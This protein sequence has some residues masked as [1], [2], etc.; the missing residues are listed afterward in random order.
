MWLLVHNT[1]FENHNNVGRRAAWGVTFSEFALVSEDSHKTFTHV[2]RHSLTLPVQTTQQTALFAHSTHLSTTPPT[3]PSFPI[4]RPP[5]PPHVLVF[6]RISQS[7]T[8]SSVNLIG[9]LGKEN[10]HFCRRRR[11]FHRQAESVKL[12]TD[13]E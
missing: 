9:V 4:E 2:L 8:H 12:E 5:T 1:K 13:R 10:V 7:Q 3:N 6:N 11:F